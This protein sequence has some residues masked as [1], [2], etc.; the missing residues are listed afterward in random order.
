M[1]LYYLLGFKLMTKYYK[2]WQNGENEKELREDVQVRQLRTIFKC[3]C[4]ACVLFLNWTQ[5]T[6][7]E[8]M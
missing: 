2:R 7:T 8:E 1:Y 6:M 5:Q 3:S 4:N